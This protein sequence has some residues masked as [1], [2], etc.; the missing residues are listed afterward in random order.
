MKKIEV[1]HLP[2][3]RRRG[4]RWLPRRTTR[5]SDR[6]STVPEFC[7]PAKFSERL[8]TGEVDDGGMHGKGGDP[9]Q[10]PLQRQLDEICGQA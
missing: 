8:L 5:A 9:L 3:E 7:S 10:F 2:V 6:P 1:A 4:R